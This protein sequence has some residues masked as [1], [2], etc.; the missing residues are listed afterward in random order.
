V[1]LAHQARQ[2]GLVTTTIGVGEDF[3]EVLLTAMADA[4]GG[5]G[6]FAP[7]ADAAPGIFAAHFDGLAS[8]V[9]QNVSVEIRPG[10]HVAVVG[11]LNDYPAVAVPGG[12]Q[13]AVGDAYG[14]EV[15]RIVFELHLPSVPA[16]GLA[17]VG[18]VVIRYVTVGDEVAMRQ[19]RVPLVVNVVTPE[20]AAGAGPDQAV[21]EEVLILRSARIRD[22]A[23]DLAS[24]GE[25]K[26][27][28]SLLA[29]TS[30]HLR[31]RAAG[32]SRAEELLAEAESL[33]RAARWLGESDPAGPPPPT[34]LKAM[35]Y[36]SHAARRRRGRGPKGV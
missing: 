5:T 29:D 4:G 8:V 15:R 14:D 22:E 34:A 23:R 17:T 36:D 26:A 11:V 19:V 24:R 30:K 9:A 33:D 20:E 12:I 28:L 1:G 2:A 35:H 7:T 10:E 27:S 3:D 32:S 13:L 18:E 31:E 16:L 6:H 21:V 25:T